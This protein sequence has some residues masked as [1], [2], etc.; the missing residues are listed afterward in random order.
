MV[1]MSI[2]YMIKKCPTVDFA[3]IHVNI[4]SI[5]IGLHTYIYTYINIYIR[6]YI[7]NTRNI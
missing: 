6:T 7:H 3:Y 5:Y 2:L 1:I 4:H